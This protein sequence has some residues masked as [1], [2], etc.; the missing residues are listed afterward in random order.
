MI[1]AE[2]LRI[3]PTFCL[4]GV[5]NRENVDDLTSPSASQET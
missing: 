2:A 1:D 5:H 3:L 4:W